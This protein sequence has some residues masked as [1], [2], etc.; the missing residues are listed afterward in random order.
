MRHYVL[1]VYILIILATIV[2]LVYEVRADHV[3]DDG[4][5]DGCEIGTPFAVF[6][7]RSNG[8]D[9]VLYSLSCR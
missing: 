6:Q 1:V 9:T 2:G 5:P 7:D 8:K 3:P 4:V